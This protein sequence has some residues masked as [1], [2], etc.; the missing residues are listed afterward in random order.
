MKKKIISLLLCG[1]MLTGCLAGCGGTGNGQPGDA[2]EAA[3][4]AEGMG[5]EIAD[6]AKEES[7][8]PAGKIELTLM[9]TNETDPWAEPVKEMV[10][11]KFPDYILTFKNWDEPTVEQ[12]VKTAFAANQAIDVVMYWPTYMKKFEGT[13]I[14]ME[15][16][17]YIEADAEW[18][19]G[20]TEGALEVGTTNEGLL[21]IPNSTNYPV[22]QINTDILD[23]AGIELK[24][25]MS[26]ED[27]MELCGKIKDYGKTPV[28]VQKDWAAWFVRNAFL[29][30]WDNR[31]ELDRFIAGE[32]SFKD[33]RVVKA[34]DNIA[35]M[36]N[37]DY[38]YPGGKEA[39]M[40][41]ADDAQAAFINGD[42]VMFC[43]VV[44]N[45]QAVSAEVGDKF[46]IGVSSWP[47]MAATEDMNVL[48]GSAG[49]FMIMSN[50]RHPDEAVEVLK[51]LTGKEVFQTMADLGSIV[52]STE[53]TSSDENYQLYSRDSNKVYPDEII[54]LS[55]EIFDN[56]VYNQPSNYLYNG[57]AALDDLDALRE[58]AISQ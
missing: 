30:C 37:S 31:E 26:W 52:P 9:I 2:G 39:V 51:Y 38:V 20:F 3:D 34:I 32:I 1:A 11:A 14:P 46:S 28:A 16:T 58:A 21:S 47:S 35:N 10:Q 22:L 43:N 19:G 45:C 24:D 17:H 49:G 7:S 15:L 8:S 55:S 23:E 27:F 50:T 33:E 6:G 53:V 40:T 13:G 41:S 25:N 5:G 4:T 48:L 36:Y 57:E 18:K 29:Q 42:A 44:A 54:N 12:T 56:M